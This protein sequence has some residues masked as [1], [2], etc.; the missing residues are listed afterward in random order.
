ML[1]PF[2]VKIAFFG[3]AFV[4]LSAKEYL[5]VHRVE[6]AK[7]AKIQENMRLDIAAIKTAAEVLN[8]RIENGEIRNLADLREGVT[9]EIAFQKI[10]IRE[11]D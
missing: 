1:K 8:E 11:D 10:A 7:R 6:S 2:H 9:N 3:A 4:V 5:K